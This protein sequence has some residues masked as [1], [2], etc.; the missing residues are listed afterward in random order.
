MKAIKS[1]VLTVGIV[2]MTAVFSAEQA[3]AQF[4]PVV[5]DN[6]YGKDNTFT[7]ACADFQSGDVVTAGVSGT[8]NIVTWID[9]N[10]ET[11]FSKRFAPEDFARINR[12]IYLGEDKILLLGS[13]KSTGNK[14]ATGRAVILN[15]KGAS[16]RDMRVGQDGTAVTFGRLLAD[17]SMILSGSSPKTG[18]G[19][20]PF[21][22]KFDKANKVLYTYTGSTGDVCDW[23]EVLGNRSEY[24]NAAL[25]SDNAG[26][27]VVR[28]DKEGKAFFITVLPDPGFRVEKMASTVDGEVYL[29]GQGPQS[30]GAVVKIRPEGDIVFQKQIVPAGSGAVLDQLMLCPTGEILAGGSNAANAYFSLL[31]PDG[32]VL[33]NVIE[34]GAVTGLSADASNGDCIV[35]LFNSATGFGKIIKMSKQGRRL[36][37]KGT[38]AEYPVMRVNANRDLLLASP[39]SG[40]LTMLSGA[41]ELLFDRYVVEN[42][43]QTFRSA[44]LPVNGEA[45]FCGANNRLA[46]LAHGI[47]VNDIT[48]NK[49][50]DGNITAVFTVTLSGYAFSDE[51]APKPVTVAYKTRP[52]SASE[53][54]NFDPVSGM[55]SF[56]P[57]VDGA[58]MYLNKFIVEVPVNANDLLEGERTFALELSDVK[59]SYLIKS[60]STATIIDQPAVVKFIGSTDGTEG[61]KDVVYTLGLFKT[62]GTQLTNA[63]KTDI[64][65]DGTY[66]NGSADRLDFEMD[67]LPRLIIQPD[68]HS[69]EFSVATLEDTRYESVKTVIVNFSTIHAMSNTV[70]SFESAALA[71]EG[72]IYDQPAMLAI[73]SLG[74][75]T[76]V[77]NVMS[78]L[79]KVSLLRARDGALQTNHSGSDIIITAAVDDSGTAV[80][81]RDF[82]VTNLHDLRIWGDDRSSA[83]NLNGLVLYSTDKEEKT[84][85]I[86]LQDVKASANAGKLSISAGGKTASFRI[87]TD[88]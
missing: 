25:S 39:K 42:T 34:S 71:C 88:K 10:G 5:Y 65:I 23:F 35:S 73:E 12:M 54:V 72:R 50:I 29:A 53:G 26:S 28:L 48:V 21:I 3:K 63:T 62:N 75:H 69:G 51:G 55:L 1:T 68:R 86:S 76:K 61:S 13:A 14:K 81:G 38:A 74:D 58:D 36:Y 52:L 84:V 44:Y 4:M 49:P 83:V 31:R 15:I 57:S 66:G 27:A 78:G 82:V 60:N 7:I 80:Q 64:V 19:N 47:Y 11:R 41:G 46:K 59:Q 56:V 77:N 20:A 16:E 2:L 70:V 18:G 32:T 33:S 67:A 6:T 30:G 87:A 79:F 85:S 17:G 8:N 22:S 45:V 43:P 37:E 9:R 40:R 24:V